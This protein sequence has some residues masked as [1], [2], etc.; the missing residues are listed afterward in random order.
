MLSTTGAAAK[1]NRTENTSEE[2]EVVAREKFR[3]LQGLARARYNEATGEKK[4]VR[5]LHGSAGGEFSGKFSRCSAQKFVLREKLRHREQAHRLEKGFLCKMLDATE[6]SSLKVVQNLREEILGKCFLEQKIRVERENLQAVHDK[7]TNSL[8]RRAAC[9]A[10]E[11][12]SYILKLEWDDKSQQAMYREENDSLR[13]TIASLKE[14]NKLDMRHWGTVASE[15][16]KLR[17]SLESSSFNYKEEI[18]QLREELFW[19]QESQK[20]LE[21][22]L[23][24]LETSHTK[25]LGMAKLEVSEENARLRERID[26]QERS[27]RNEKEAHQ[28][29]VCKLS[30]ELLCIQNSQRQMQLHSDALKTVHAAELESLTKK[31]HDYINNDSV[32]AHLNG[33][34]KDQG[35]HIE[36][37]KERIRQQLKAHFEEVRGLREA[38]VQAQESH[39]K[40]LL[41]ISG[42]LEAADMHRAKE[43]AHF[44][45]ELEFVKSKKNEICQE[46][47]FRLSSIEEDIDPCT[48]RTA[49]RTARACLEH[50][51]SIELTDLKS[52][53]TTLKR[54][55]C[56]VKPEN[57]KYIMD[58]IEENHDPDAEAKVLGEIY[59]MALS[60]GEM[61]E[62]DR[63]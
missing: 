62:N 48:T 32:I 4:E 60:L 28:I 45:A 41:Q 51:S 38:F 36:G 20:Q 8:L 31:T 42:C 50:E 35:D 10:N 16:K 56:A 33:I 21:S 49:L 2:R 1:G 11:K 57:L 7:E 26:S 18:H 14:Q 46:P 30:D 61:H 58:K 43:V 9:V 40:D 17:E 5:T 34:I 44:V 19:S 15:N 3:K 25:E 29:E 39:K 13:Q 54:L 63:N 23:G 22:E 53:A 6:K 52:F 12:E 47:A 59:R 27:L 37:E 24:E 55:Q